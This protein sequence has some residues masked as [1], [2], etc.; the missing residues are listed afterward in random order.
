MFPVA[1]RDE[2]LASKDQ[3]FGLIFNDSPKA[4]ILADLAQSPVLNDTV[5]GLS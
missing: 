4:Y 5:G 3:V 1:Q 2:R